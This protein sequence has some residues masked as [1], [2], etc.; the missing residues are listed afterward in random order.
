MD[1]A[2]ASG[3]RTFTTQAGGWVQAWN[4]RLLLII[5]RI[6]EESCGSIL[7]LD[8]VPDCQLNCLWPIKTEDYEAYSHTS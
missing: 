5:T 3:L 6:K 4:E 2:T 1:E 7:R 8:W